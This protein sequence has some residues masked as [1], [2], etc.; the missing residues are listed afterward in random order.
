LTREVPQA[1]DLRFNSE[2][3]ANLEPGVLRLIP[4]LSQPTG[5]QLDGDGFGFE[6]EESEADKFRRYRLGPGDTLLIIVQRFPDLS[7]QGSIN[8][9]GTIV[10]PLL[11]TL[12]LEGLTLAEAQDTIRVALDRFVIDPDVS[13]SL[14]A[15]RPVQVTIIGEIQRPGFYPLGSTRVS[16]ALLV[17]GGS[18]AT[19]D[20]REI[21]VR[22]TLLDGSVIEQTVDLYTPLAE[23]KPAPSLRLEDGDVVVIPP[24]TLLEDP[25]YDRTLVARSTVIKPTITVRILSYAAGAGGTLNLPSNSTFRDALNGIPLNTARVNRIALIRYDPATGQPVQ[26]IL[27][28]RKAL[29]GDPEQDVPLQDNDVIVVGRNLITNITFWLGRV[30]QPFR[31]VLGFLLFFDSLRD[32]AGN[33][34]R[35][36]GN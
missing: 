12:A 29:S 25:N 1:V 20:L 31:D 33:L 4:S 6:Q 9:E 22:R 35:P 5:E 36:T 8:P 16:D 27:N 15:Q 21:Q 34:F 24:L 26:Q 3:A 19:A 30:T 28:G 17:A 18:L 11:G 2:P 14:L 23:G 10:M 7:F 32:S 13:L